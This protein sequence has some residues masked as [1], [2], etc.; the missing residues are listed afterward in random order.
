MKRI[1]ESQ[2]NGVEYNYYDATTYRKGEHNLDYDDLE[3]CQC[4]QLE[5]E[6]AELKVQIANLELMLG[7][8]GKQDDKVKGIEE[9]NLVNGD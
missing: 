4:E 9:A 5:K 6:N 3:D 1:S 2:F 7:W 8:G